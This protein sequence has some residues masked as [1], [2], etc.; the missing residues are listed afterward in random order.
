MK[1]LFLILLSLYLYGNECITCHSDKMKQCKNSN[2]FTHKNEINIVRKTWGM[3]DSNVTLQNLPQATKDIKKPNDLVDDLLRRKCLR[4]HLNNKE[5]NP[6]KNLCLACHNKHSSKLDSLKAKPTQEKCLKCHNNNYIGTDYLGLFPHDYDKAYR[7]PLT[8]DGYYPNRPYGIDFH[9][10]SSD[11]HQKKGMSCIDCHKKTSTKQWEDTLNCSSCHTHLSTN[12]HH[13]YHKNLS[14]NS[15]HSSWNISNYELNLLRDDTSNYKQWQRLTLQEDP[16]LEKF[17][18][19]AL[20]SKEPIE[21]KMLDYLSNKLKQGIWYSG[22]RFRRWENFFLI[23][24]K[25]GK[26]KIASP[27]YQ[28]RISYK[29]ANEKIIFDDVNKIDGEKIEAFLPRDPHTITSKSKSCEMCHENK[30]MLDKNLINKNILQG[31]ILKGSP[32]SQKQLQK[33]QSAK[34]KLQRAKTLF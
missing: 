11:I 6:T 1:F 24:D 8:K 22:W 4:C 25:N 19:K 21:P 26:I 16:Y 31:K 17:L 32:L 18:K 27:M 7:T 10:L 34:Y 15:C 29:D 20:K 2:H 9:H 13:T 12:N 3:H 5:I 30:I 28:Y 33:L 23:N 14:C